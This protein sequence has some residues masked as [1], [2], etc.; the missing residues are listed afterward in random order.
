LSTYRLSAPYE[1]S[2]LRRRLS[3]FAL[4][5]AINLGLLLLLMS[6]GIV[7]APLKK[8]AP[9]VVIPSQ[10]VVPPSRSIADFRFC[11]ASSCVVRSFRCGREGAREMP[12]RKIRSCFFSRND[13]F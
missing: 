11:V 7:P 2:P 8:P 13:F 6:L 1:R 5:L 12:W 4:A 3:G 9:T 10:F